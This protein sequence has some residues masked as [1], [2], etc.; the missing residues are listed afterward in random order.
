LPRVS[1]GEH[2]PPAD[3][4]ASA[5]SP[6][7]HV[8]V[9]TP[10]VPEAE[11]AVRPATVH[12]TPTTPDID[13]RYQGPFTRR[14]QWIGVALLGLSGV[15]ATAVLLVTLARWLLG[16]EVI[17][18]FVESY[19][20]ESHLP[21]GAPVGF[22]AWL[23]W[24]HFLNAFLMLLIIRS[25]MTIRRERRPAAY[26]SGNG[27]KVSLTVW[28][29]Q[30]L[31]LLWLANGLVFVVLLF[32]TGQWMRVVPAS[33]DVLPNALSALLQY[34]SL[35]W[36][37]ENGWVSYNALQLLAY[38]VTIFVAAPMSALTGFRMS[39]L[40]PKRATYMSRLFPVEWARRL[41]FPVMIYFVVFIFIHIALVLSTGALRNLNHMYAAQGST[42]PTEYAENWV[43]FCWF[44]ASLL[45]MVAGW[46]V[47]RTAM[48]APIAGRFGTVTSR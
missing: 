12:A 9:V 23:A 42:D 33:I 1:G 34:L 5:S 47:A 44:T 18:Q 24:Q 30:S 45:V 27:E 46:S 26:W 8:E 41:H 36:P 14:Q 16:L 6:I 38:F 4:S 32:S 35:N 17:E 3:I 19:P 37:T 48:L 11:L 43:G 13:L 2:W 40:W 31:D 29:H 25:G 22:P 39:G 7:A 28:F 10:E 21:E 20:G 15:L